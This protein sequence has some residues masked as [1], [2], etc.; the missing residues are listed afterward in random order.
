MN[1]ALRKALRIS[2]NSQAYGILYRHVAAKQRN[3]LTSL[4]FGTSPAGRNRY[5]R[6]RLTAN[7]LRPEETGG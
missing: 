6:Y 4:Q 1:Y 3:S 2:K 5:N 7:S